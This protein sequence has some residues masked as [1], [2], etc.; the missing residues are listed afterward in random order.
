MMKQGCLELINEMNIHLGEGQRTHGKI[1]QWLRVS[2]ALPEVW[3]SASR[4]SD[5]QFTTAGNVAVGDLMPLADFQRH[6]HMFANA[7][8]THV[9][10]A[11]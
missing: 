7:H 5:W 6:A 8:Y 3:C 1:T 11:K 9:N 10:K 2:A 4:S